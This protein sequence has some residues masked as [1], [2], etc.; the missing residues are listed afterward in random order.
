MEDIRIKFN[1]IKFDTD[2]FKNPEWGLENAPVG[3]YVALA[4]NGDYYICNHI[5]GLQFICFPCSG[6]I[7]EE[8]K[9]RQSNQRTLTTVHQSLD[10][11]LDA[12]N[13]IPK[14]IHKEFDNVL[15]EISAIKISNR[16]EEKVARSRKEDV[17]K[18]LN[19]LTI[20]DIWTTIAV[21]QQPELIK[22][23]R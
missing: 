20:K 6:E 13:S 4:P 19:I 17:E 12:I 1:I 16:K 11:M 21:I 2:D 22:E 5:K 18:A 7:I 15:S 23:L 9:V 8:A 10:Q 3:M 14:K